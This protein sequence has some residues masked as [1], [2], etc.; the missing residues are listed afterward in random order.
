M[1]R[2]ATRL[3]LGLAA[4]LLLACSTW[5]ADYLA[6]HVERA[7]QAEVEQKLGRPVLTRPLDGGGTEWV[8]HVFPRSLFDYPYRGHPYGDGSCEEYLLTFDQQGILTTW[9]KQDC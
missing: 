1:R 5:Q 6:Q 2:E 8:Y 3:G 9:L 7:T 4:G